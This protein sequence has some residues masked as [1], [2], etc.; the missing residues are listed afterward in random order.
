MKKIALFGGSFDPPHV[1]HINLALEVM[2]RGGFDELFWIPANL[3]PLRQNEQSA[4]PQQRLEMVK[5]AVAPIKGFLAL[6]VEIKR[7]PP[8]Y[9]IDTINLLVDDKHSYS[10]L[11]TDDVYD[12]FFQ[13]KDY[14]KIKEKVDIVVVKREKSGLEIPRMEISSTRIRERLKKKLYC[15][16]LLPSIV[17]DYIYENQLYSIP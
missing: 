12:T 14:E 10:L 2:E 4:A 7:P 15:G 3:S 1:G 13:W 8:S 5:L 6:D 16:H 9:T 11:L 17:L